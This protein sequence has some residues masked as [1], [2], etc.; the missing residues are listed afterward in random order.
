MYDK[1]SRWAATTIVIYLANWFEANDK[2]WDF[3][4]HLPK[5]KKGAK[6][7]P[8]KAQEEQEINLFSTVVKY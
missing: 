8:K 7:V 3:F 5:K 1:K 6:R 2:T 4:Y